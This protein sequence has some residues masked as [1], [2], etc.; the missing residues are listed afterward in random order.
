MV[1]FV[2]VANSVHV[3]HVMVFVVTVYVA[4]FFGS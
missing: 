2:K 1:N 3:P 4:D